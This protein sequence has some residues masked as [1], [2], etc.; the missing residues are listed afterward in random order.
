[1]G[2]KRIGLA[3]LE[4]LLENLKRE[5]DLSQTRLLGVV[6]KYQTKTA[7]YTCVA[8]DSGTTILVNPA[9]TTLIQLPG[10]SDVETGWNVTIV[11]DEQDG[12][13]MDQIVNIGTKAGEFFQGF[14]IASDGGGNDFAN[15]AADDFINCSTSSTSG[16]VIHIVN[17]GTFMHVTGTIVDATD[18]KFAET[19]AA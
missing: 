17:D 7:N 16:E 18:T 8:A 14:L 1:M 4:A 19:A 5:I 10:V 6:K 12:G 11:I 15:P 3:R 9:A 2:S 13:T